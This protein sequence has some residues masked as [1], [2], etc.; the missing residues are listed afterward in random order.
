MRRVL[1]PTVRSGS[2]V[3]GQRTRW[4]I[5]IGSTRAVRGIWRRSSGGGGA[6]RQA[7]RVA[8][9]VVLFLQRL[10]LRCLPAVAQATTQAK[11][12]SMVRKGCLCT[13]MTSSTQTLQMKN[14]RKKKPR[15][16]NKRKLA[17]PQ[18]H[19]SV[20][21]SIA[22]SCCLCRVP[23]GSSLD[24]VPLVTTA[25]TARMAP[26]EGEGWT[27]WGRVCLRR[28]SSTAVPRIIPSLSVLIATFVI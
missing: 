26:G 15:E 19:R 17:L 4:A 11:A 5:C 16:D 6:W 18:R 10:A 2:S 14:Y 3:V 21:C 20:P 28:G 9:G 25:Q 7:Q 12:M 22:C 27:D 24:E 8:P 23:A 13:R 1:W